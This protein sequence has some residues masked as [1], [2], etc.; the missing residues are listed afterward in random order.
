MANMNIVHEVRYGLKSIVQLKCNMCNLE[1]SLNTEEETSMDINTASVAGAMAIG[2][3][4]SQLEEL[5][6]AM[7]VPAMSQNT[8]AKYHD[9]VSD[10][11]E[12]TAL[13]EM[14]AAVK[15]EI[16]HAVEEGQVSPDGIPILTV[17][18]DGSWAKRSYRTMRSLE[19]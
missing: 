14:E 16:D 19:W 8:Y 10:A 1:C 12:K 18:I 6:S 17:V 5:L 4:Y 9:L 11:W 3:G 7:E 15:A 13:Q 2:I